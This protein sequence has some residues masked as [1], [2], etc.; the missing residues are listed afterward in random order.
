[1]LT[2]LDAH[3]ID[4]LVTVSELADVI[5]GAFGASPRSAFARSAVDVDGGELLLMPAAHAGTLTVKTLTLFDA[6]PAHGLPS[7]QGL[8]TVFD[9]VTGRP[10]AV[11]DAAAVTRLR[12][13][14]VTVSATDRLARP[15]ARVLTVVGAGAQ[16]RGHLAGLARIRPWTEIRL[17]S[18][19][20]DKARAVASW[21]RGQG[22]DIEVEVHESLGTAIAGA[23][24]ICTLTSSADPLFEDAALPREGLHVSA[25]GGY[26]S[27]RRELP[28]AL[29]ARSSLFVESAEAALREAGD[30]ILAVKDGALPPHPPLTE[31]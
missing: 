17:H 9:A 11:L 26:G 13:A 29:V 15:D 6:A 23:D 30:L 3:A 4:G 28:A 25:V 31:L 27:A 16:A 19:G 10:L 14:A 1:M 5:G 18:R 12:T 7:V 20:T 22:L 21:A 24:V 8:A 2:F